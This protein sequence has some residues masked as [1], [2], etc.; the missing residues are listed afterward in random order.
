MS[1]VDGSHGLLA[2]RVAFQLARKML[3]QH[4]G[5]GGEIYHQILLRHKS[6]ATYEGGKINEEQGCVVIAEGRG[7]GNTKGLVVSNICILSCNGWVI[8]SNCCNQLL[9]WSVIKR[10]LFSCVLNRSLFL[11]MSSVSFCDVLSGRFCLLCLKDPIGYKSQ[12]F[13]GLSWYYRLHVQ[14]KFI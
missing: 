10:L 9:D 2:S 12:D 14:F 5:G 8:H 1:R 13:Y 3:R 11:Y 7:G 4:R 6:S